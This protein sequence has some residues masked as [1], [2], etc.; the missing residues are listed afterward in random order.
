[1]GE[2]DSTEDTLDHIATVSRYINQVI[3]CLDARTNAHDSSKLH[4]PEKEVFD[5]YTPKL[6]ELTYGSD[7]YK[8]ALKGMKQGLQ[9]HYSA[10]RHHPEHFEMGMLDMNL[11]DLVEMLCDWKAASERHED[12]DIYKSIVINQ[13]RFHYSNDVKE[14]LLNTAK[15]LGWT[16]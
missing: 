11:M 2:Y 16:S 5:E 14:L 10:N 13:E 6:K 3:S 12:G 8:E 15:R 7:E 1:M 4:P 9:H